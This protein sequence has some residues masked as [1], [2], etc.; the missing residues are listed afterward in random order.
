MKQRITAMLLILFSKQF[1]VI[2]ETTNEVKASPH[3]IDASIEL[4]DSIY[5]DYA[6]QE[7]AVQEV[8]DIL[9]CGK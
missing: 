5:D 8:Y 7:D 3:L 4:L 1:I 9:N 6:I 2:T